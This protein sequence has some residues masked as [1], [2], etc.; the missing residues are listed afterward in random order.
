VLA[1]SSEI[2]NFLVLS[3]YVFDACVT[4]VLQKLNPLETEA[5]RS[6]LQLVLGGI[7][8]QIKHTGYRK[9]TLSKKHDIS[10]TIDKQVY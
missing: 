4:K 5:Y 9:S 2:K 10:K 7:Q 8:Q 6:K 3:Y 1:H